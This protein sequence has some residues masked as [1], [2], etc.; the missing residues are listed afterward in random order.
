M[1]TGCVVFTSE[2]EATGYNGDSHSIGSTKP[3]QLRGLST[4][5][6]LNGGVREGEEVVRGKGERGGV[7]EGQRERGPWL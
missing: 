7:R 1:K 3:S 2:A 6:K 5:K 4:E